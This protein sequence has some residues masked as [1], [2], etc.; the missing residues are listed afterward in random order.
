MMQINGLISI[1]EED[2]TPYWVYYG[3]ELVSNQPVINIKW[4]IIYVEI[5]AVICFQRIKQN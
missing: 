1:S 4:T 2:T 3:V 5:G